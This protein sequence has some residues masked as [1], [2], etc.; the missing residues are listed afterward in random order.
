MRSVATLATHVVDSGRGEDVVSSG[1]HGLVPSVAGEVGSDPFFLMNELKL[2]GK[3]IV[4]YL[5]L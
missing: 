5:L 4:I 3:W 2:L 1:D